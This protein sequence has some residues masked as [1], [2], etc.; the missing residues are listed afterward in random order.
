[1][2]VIPAVANAVYDAVGVR[3]DEIPISPDKVLAALE[4]KRKGGERRTGP[5]AVPSFRFRDPIKV[6]PPSGWEAAW[7]E[8]API[9][10]G[11]GGLTSHLHT[12]TDLTDARPRDDRDQA[13]EEP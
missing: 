1:L 3:I 4:Q 6:D 11:A 8:P 9:A 2:P 10:G 12:G 5:R 7:R 13:P